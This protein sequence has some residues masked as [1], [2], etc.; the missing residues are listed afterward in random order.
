[1]TFLKEYVIRTKG[2][3]VLEINVTWAPFTDK[4]TANGV[5]T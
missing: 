2:M 4:M 3:D 1:M 5:Q